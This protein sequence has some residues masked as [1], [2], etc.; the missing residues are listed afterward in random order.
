MFVTVWVGN[1]GLKHQLPLSV[2]SNIKASYHEFSTQHLSALP[3]R[4]IAW[5]NISRATRESI[6]F[7]GLRRVITQHDTTL[8][9]NGLISRQS[10]HL[11]AELLR[12]VNPGAWVWEASVVERTRRG[13]LGEMEEQG[14]EEEKEEECFWLCL[15]TGMV[16]DWL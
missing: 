14:E 8:Y 7:R 6:N 1:G 9:D 13:G 15:T 11:H 16:T 3:I 4:K 10:Q 5:F 12:W 2:I